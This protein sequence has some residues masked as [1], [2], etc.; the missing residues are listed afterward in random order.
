[1]GVTRGKWGSLV[2]SLFDFKRDFD[3]NLPLSDALPALVAA[4]PDRYG[5]MGLADLAEEMHETMRATSQMDRLHD[6]FSTLPG[7]ALLPAE[8]YARVV[9]GAVEPVRLREMQQRTVA[10]GVVPYPPG[11][12]LLMPGEQT[13]DDTD[14][15]SGT[16][17]RC[18]TSIAG[19]PVS[20]T[21]R[22]EW[23]ASTVNTSYS[24]SPR[25]SGHE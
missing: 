1:M 23:R 6:A 2:T 19:S 25:S 18:R 21:T 13:G 10:V 4:H 15:G 9:R 20:S 5:A 11:I 7:Q 12:P 17:R 8:A 3:R 22:T 16:S 24:A 14:R